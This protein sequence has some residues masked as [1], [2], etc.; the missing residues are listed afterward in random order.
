MLARICNGIRAH[1]GWEKYAGILIDT[2][3]QILERHVAGCAGPAAAQLGGICDRIAGRGAQRERA[4]VHCTLGCKFSGNNSLVQVLR[5]YMVDMS[6]HFWECNS[7]H[8]SRY[9][10]VRNGAS[11]CTW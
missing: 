2:E 10:Y 1:P 5:V 7:L 9:R 8:I 4:Q 6:N 3:T 11:W